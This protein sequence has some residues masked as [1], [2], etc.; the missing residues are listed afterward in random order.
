MLD[1]EGNLPEPCRRSKHQV[2]FEY[3]DDEL[4]DLASAMAS[5]ST[6]DWEANIDD[7]V[8]TTFAAPLSI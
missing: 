2:V 5:V 7:N 3:E 6:S 4:I 1:F 8:S